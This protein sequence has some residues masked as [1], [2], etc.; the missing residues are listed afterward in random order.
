VVVLGRHDAEPAIARIA[1]RY[2][3]QTGHHPYVFAGSS[4]GVASS[5]S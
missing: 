4:S 5:T 2:A 1:E 3:F